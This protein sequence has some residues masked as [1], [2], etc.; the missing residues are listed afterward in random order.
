MLSLKT[1]VLV[2]L[3]SPTQLHLSAGLPLTKVLLGE[4]W[5]VARLEVSLAEQVGVTA[6]L[7]CWT[8]TQHWQFF[9]EELL[10]EH[11]HWGEVNPKI[12]VLVLWYLQS[13][14]WTVALVSL[15]VTFWHKHDSNVEFL[16]VH[17]GGWGIATW[18]EVA[19]HE[20]SLFL[21]PDGLLTLRQL[22]DDK[23]KSLK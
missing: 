1:V 13:H 3:R 10:R 7:Y 15:S 16:R 11:P 8:V 21:R 9:T 2:C 5:H 17:V 18:A 23:V 22:Q 12:V 19:Q 14:D 4:H 20:H 6:S